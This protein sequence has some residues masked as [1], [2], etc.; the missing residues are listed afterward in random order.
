MAQLGVG[1]LR[2]LAD[3]GRYAVNWPLERLNRSANLRAVQGYSTTNATYTKTRRKKEPTHKTY[4]V[5]NPDLADQTSSLRAK[6]SIDS[7]RKEKRDAA[8]RIQQIQEMTDSDLLELKRSEAVDKLKKK[9]R[10]Q[11]RMAVN[12]YQN[13]AVPGDNALSREE[14]DLVLYA[15]KCASLA[16]EPTKN[17]KSVIPSITADFPIMDL[18]RAPV[19]AQDGFM[20]WDNDRKMLV[21]AFKGTDNLQD[22][23]TDLNTYSVSTLSKVNGEDLTVPL[24]GHNGFIG[25]FINLY[26]QVVEGLDSLYQVADPEMEVYPPILITGH[27]L[28]GALATVCAFVLCQ[29]LPRA[30]I[31]LITFE[32]PRV[33]TVGTLEKIQGYLPTSQVENNA[34]RISARNDIVPS[35][36]PDLAG[37]RHVGRNYYIEEPFGE[38]L[39]TSLAKK[40]KGAFDWVIGNEPTKIDGRFH[41]M[42]NVDKA[43]QHY[44]NLN[45]AEA[46][47]AYMTLT[48]ARG[49]I[50]K[51]KRTKI[52]KKGSKSMKAYMAYV[53]SFKNSK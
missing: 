44:S 31:Q 19:P 11:M 12:P 15:A 1:S 45:S 6:F 42:D 13:L 17:I 46:K 35:M 21:I 39:I 25:R 23:W 43:L 2:Q 27:S 3:T 33:F 29:L 53:R 40:L 52:G 50:G 14:T 4:G 18:T 8:K 32:S 5:Y 47:N 36:P 48:S 7:E 28:G 24:Y 51:K 22:L 16:Y 38:F 26:P 41:S 30:P 49:V 37:F 34:I 20:G 10:N 9:L